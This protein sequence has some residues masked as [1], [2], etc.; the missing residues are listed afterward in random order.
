MYATSVYGCFFFPARS[1][2]SMRVSNY[3]NLCY[4]YPREA[5]EPTEP[6]SRHSPLKCNTSYVLKYDLIPLDSAWPKRRPQCL[7][8]TQNT[9]FA[10]S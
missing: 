5:L 1:P 4:G 2:I 8:L 7:K 9:G 10:H 6:I 3:V